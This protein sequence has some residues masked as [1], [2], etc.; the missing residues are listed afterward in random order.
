[1]NHIAAVLLISLAGKTVDK[2]SLEDVLVAAG[3]K[4]VPSVVETILGA[5]KNKKP[6]QIVKEGLSKLASTVGVSAPTS[7]VVAA[8]TEEKKD[9]KKDDKKDAKKD[10][11]KKEA[12]KKK[13]VEPEDDEDVGF[14]G[15]F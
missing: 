9:A 12:P 5:I 11:K 1:M 7:T 10:D 4:P 6:E 8:P 14:G 2:K 13:E 15:L 3:S